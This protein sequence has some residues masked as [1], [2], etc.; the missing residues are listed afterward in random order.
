LDPRVLVVIAAG[1]FSALTPNLLAAAPSEDCARLAQLQVPKVTIVSAE[2]VGA[3]TFNPP[4]GAVLTIE[5]AFCRVAAVARPSADSDIKF[6]VWLPVDWNGRM[7][8]VGNGDFAGNISYRGLS[9]HVSEKY[10]TVATDAGHAAAS[11]DTTWALAILRRS[12]TSV[13]VRFMRRRREQSC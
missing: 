1:L 4:T 12:S 3:G 9:T 7:W 11:M 10:A 5:K 6:E 13:I 8:G 2:L